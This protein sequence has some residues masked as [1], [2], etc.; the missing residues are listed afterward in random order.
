[1]CEC[2]L[3]LLGR[4]DNRHEEEEREEEAGMVVEKGDGEEVSDLIY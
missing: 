1:M 2:I 3:K 4:M